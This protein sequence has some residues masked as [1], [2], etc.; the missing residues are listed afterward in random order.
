MEEGASN[1]IKMDEW[2]PKVVSNLKNFY[3]EENV[4]RF[5]NLL[6]ETEGLVAGGFVLQSCIGGSTEYRDIDIYVPVK[7]IPKFIHEMF[8]KENPIIMIDTTVAYGASLYC[9]SFLRKNGIRKVYSFIRNSYR[10]GIDPPRRA[11]DVM[12]VRT[13]RNPLAV[14]NNF[15]LTFCQVWYDG[16][17]VFASHPDDIKTKSGKLQKDYCK[18]L[19]EGNRFLKR[20][21]K[22]Y[23]D[24][25][26]K[27]GFDDGCVNNESILNDILSQVYKKSCTLQEKDNEPTYF[28]HWFQRIAIKWFNGYRDYNLNIDNGNPNPADKE[29]NVLIVP[30]LKDYC[31]TD[32]DLPGSWCQYGLRDKQLEWYGAEDGYDSDEYDDETG[33]ELAVKNFTSIGPELSD[34]A[35][36]RKIKYLRALTSL[37]INTN[38][39]IRYYTSMNHIIKGFGGSINDTPEPKPSTDG[40]GKTIL[41]LFKKL[42]KVCLP[43]GEDQF[44]G[45]GPLYHIHNHPFEGGITQE[46][47]EAYL[48]SV[49]LADDMDRLPC[50]YKPESVAPGAPSNPKN[51]SQFLTLRLIKPIVSTEFYRRLTAPRPK[52]DGLDQEIINFDLVFRNSKSHDEQWGDIYHVTMCPFCLLF[53]ERGEGCAYMVHD[54]PDKLGPDQSPYCKKNRVVVPLVKMYTTLAKRLDNGYS[55]LE[56]C[57]ECGRPCSG[58]KHFNLDGTALIKNNIVPDPRRPGQQMIDYGN[59]PGGGRVE[60]VARMLAVIDAYKI[61]GLR[62]THEERKYAARMADTAPTRPEYIERAKKIMEKAP[63]QRKWDVYV[64][65][66]KAYTNPLYEGVEDNSAWNTVLPANAIVPAPNP[67]AAAANIENIAEPINNLPNIAFQNEIPLPNIPAINA[68]PNLGANNAMPNQLPVLQ[69]EPPQQGGMRSKKSRRRKIR[70]KRTTKSKKK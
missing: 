55:R 45:E 9:R 24:M 52:K 51:C 26:F 35:N 8:Q 3:G 47:L 20:R 27:I 67:N 68:Q 70:S 33:T 63:A 4:E 17:S 66:S 13:K 58:H 29:N 64:P 59:C 6:K 65:K 37:F 19:L 11:M 14:V 50:Y 40:R 43:E 25:G 53:V 22:K 10:R 30:L 42:K 1:G 69:Q 48:E 54:N 16:E 32:M 39:E 28:K 41:T 12:S 56:F 23:I 38:T 61:K 34:E 18:T 46:S 7:N 57:V 5:R 2:V 31:R 62:D 49:M 60:M 44:G 36:L 21:V 15:D